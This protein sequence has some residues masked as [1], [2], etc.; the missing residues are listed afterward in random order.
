[1][2]EMSHVASDLHLVVTKLCPASHSE[3]PQHKKQQHHITVFANNTADVTDDVGHF[4][5]QYL[6]LVQLCKCANSLFSKY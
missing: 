6:I 3:V 4:S 2:Q 1:M 5:H